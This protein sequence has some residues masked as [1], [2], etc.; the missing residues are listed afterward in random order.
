MTAEI[1]I[2]NRSAISMA[3][4]SVVTVGD[5]KTYTGVNKLFMLSNN[6]PM[7]IMIYGNAD[8]MEMPMESLIKEYRKECKVQNYKTV[9]EFT[10]NFMIFLKKYSFSK[11]DPEKIFKDEIEDFEKNMPKDFIN[12][13]SSEINESLEAINSNLGENLLN[14]AKSD[15]L[16]EYGSYFDKIIE[17]IFEVSN[18]QKRKLKELLQKIFIHNLNIQSTGIVI[19]GFNEEDIYPS[20]CANNIL[21]VVKDRLWYDEIFKE[22]N[23]K[24]PVIRPFAQ[25]DVVNTFLVGLDIEI[26]NNIG[27]FFEKTI[28]DY[29]NKILETIEQNEKIKGEPLENLREEINLISEKNDEILND[30]TNVITELISKSA[31]PLLNSI[32]VLPKEE[33]GNMAES[34]IHITSLKRKVEDGLETVGGDID[35]AIIS[36]GD[37]FIWTK[38]KHYFNPEL[39]YQFFDR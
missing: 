12:K 32:G 29:P 16:K 19:A 23:Q 28:N 21:T 38:R 33:L 20:F 25:T 8:F 13:I 30:Y 4:D 2:M 27:Y 9:N 18:N 39:N 10:E 35:V 34:L 14:M 7:G 5:K 22:E 3:A 37:G 36:K 6:P 1:L 26:V 17:N 24:F 15:E 11:S 31:N